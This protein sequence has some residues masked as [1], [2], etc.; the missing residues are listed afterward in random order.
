[1]WGKVSRRWKIIIPVFVVA[2][3]SLLIY[4][5]L[6]NNNR[7]FEDIFPHNQAEN[8]LSFKPLLIDN[9]KDI[10]TKVRVTIIL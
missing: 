7:I 2:T 1:M 5:I 8:T 6:F 3:V 9:Q 4:S 10:L